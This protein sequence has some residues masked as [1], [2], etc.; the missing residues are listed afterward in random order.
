[1]Q[2]HI[3]FPVIRALY[4][5]IEYLRLQTTIVQTTIYKTHNQHGPTV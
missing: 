2:D 1:M 3:P 5:N 4:L